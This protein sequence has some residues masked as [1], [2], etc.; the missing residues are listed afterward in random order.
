M[1]AQTHRRTLLKHLAAAG[2]LSP[3]VTACTPAKR[4]P[5]RI[6]A[7]PFPGYE[8]IYLARELQFFTE[9]QIKLIETP[10]ASSNLRGLITR[11]LDGAFLTLDEVLTSR[12]NGVDLRVVALLDES[13]GADVLIAHNRVKTLKNLKG[14]TIGVEQ[15]A[16]GAVLLNAALDAA[17]LTPSDIQTVYIPIENHLSYFSD[18]KVDAVVTYEPTKSKILSPHT[19]ALFSSASIPGQIIDTIAMRSEIIESK[20]IEIKLLVESHFKARMAWKS[21]PEKHAP[22]MA[23]RLDLSAKDVPAAFDEIYLTDEQENKQWMT[24]TPAKLM[25]HAQYLG[26]LMV[27]H[28]LLKSPPDL[29]NLFTPKFLP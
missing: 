16:T 23:G 26:E 27:R 6:A 4:D 22:A 3:L 18:G 28:E 2:V 11:S 20:S 13:R 7:Q 12:A 8:L 24:G 14:K 19:H 5:L 17:G 21:T 15:T 1:S 10:S 25:T 9:N 29:K